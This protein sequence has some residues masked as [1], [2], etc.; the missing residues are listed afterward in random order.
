MNDNTKVEID[1]EEYL[2]LFRAA[3]ML[4]ALEA[5]GVDNW[6]GYSEVDRDLVNK[7]VEEE[8]KKL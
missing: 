6:E 5:A 4:D 3:R 7:Q 1:R 8:E 2:E